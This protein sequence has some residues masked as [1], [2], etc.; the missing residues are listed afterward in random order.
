MEQPTEHELITEIEKDTEVTARLLGA[1]GLVDASLYD[2]PT[3]ERVD[4]VWTQPNIILG[5]D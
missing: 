3:T 4:S 2:H 1:L 5:S